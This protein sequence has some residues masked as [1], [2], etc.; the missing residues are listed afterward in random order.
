MT[1]GAFSRSLGDVGA[2]KK[3]EEEGLREMPSRRCQKEKVGE[4]LP[5]RGLG[6]GKVK[7]VERREVLKLGEES[8]DRLRL[9]KTGRNG[10]EVIRVVRCKVSR[11]GEKNKRMGGDSVRAA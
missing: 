8:R 11:K 1:C 7:N 6:K 5:R 10:G 4:R 9:I 2:W 3:R